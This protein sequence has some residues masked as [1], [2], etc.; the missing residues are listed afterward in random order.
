MA[1]NL[2]ASVESLCNQGKI[3]LLK[4]LIERE[5]IHGWRC[6]AIRYDRHALVYRAA[7][8]LNALIGWTQH[9]A[10]SMQENYGTALGGSRSSSATDLSV[11][12]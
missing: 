5:N 12:M 3:H 6:L 8:A 10:D 1:K 7:V 9:S 4:D 11:S 2:T